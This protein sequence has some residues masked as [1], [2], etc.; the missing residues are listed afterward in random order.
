MVRLI[1]TFQ[2]DWD[3]P[4]H[5][6]TIRSL[7]A[8]KV[9]A[10][11]K[12]QCSEDVGKIAKARQNFLRRD[13]LICTPGES[14]SVLRGPG[15]VKGA[16]DASEVDLMITNLLQEP[17]ELRSQTDR[18]PLEPGASKVL[19]AHHGDLWM[20]MAAGRKLPYSHFV[21]IANGKVQDMV[22]GDMNG[23]GEKKQCDAGY[24]N[25]NN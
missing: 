2:T 16:W 18:V 25:V 23:L 11:A 21:D 20:S 3:T 19:L 14:C 12:T 8:A 13:Q 1:E 7:L 5:R 10:V 17:V 6:H 4:H 9:A 22:I 24:E 15:L